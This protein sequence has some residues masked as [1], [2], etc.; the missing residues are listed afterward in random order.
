MPITNTSKQPWLAIAAWILVG[1]LF[2]WQP[3]ESFFEPGHQ[4]YLLVAAGYA[5]FVLLMCI[6][7]FMDAPI[8][9]G[10]FTRRQIIVSKVAPFAARGISAVGLWLRWA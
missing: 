7:I 5:L 2:I 4:A 1:A 3:L 10:R 8:N 9:R 6:S